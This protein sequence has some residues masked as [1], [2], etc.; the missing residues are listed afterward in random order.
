MLRDWD[1][2][3]GWVARVRTVWRLLIS[4]WPF[5]LWRSTVFPESSQV[6]FGEDSLAPGKMFGIAE[7]VP[8]DS[9]TGD[10]PE[11]ML[12]DRGALEDES[13]HGEQRGQR[14]HCG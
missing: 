11:R 5:G 4:P 10:R 12:R 13:R 1:R 9:L 3:F 7:Y 8:K 6:C 2:P 14:S